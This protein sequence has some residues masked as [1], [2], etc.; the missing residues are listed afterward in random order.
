M[1]GTMTTPAATATSCPTAPHGNSAACHGNPH[2]TPMSTTPRARV[3]ARDR[4]IGIGLE[5]EFSVP[6]NT[7]VCRGGPWKVAWYYCICC[8]RFP[9]GGATAMPRYVAKKDNN[10]SG[11][12]AKKG[13]NVHLP[14]FRRF[15]RPAQRR[16]ACSE[17]WR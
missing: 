1:R 15:L 17:R 8:G 2:G 14:D 3:R 16:C 5:L 10:V 9:A 13:N 7:V 4:V 11:A 6:W 12:V